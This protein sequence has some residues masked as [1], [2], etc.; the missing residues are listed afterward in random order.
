MSEGPGR[1]WMLKTGEVRRTVRD[2][3]AAGTATVS[4]QIA[5]SALAK[6]RDVPFS[7]HCCCS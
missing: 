7:R 6:S 2:V 5:G 4:V 3:N 1:C